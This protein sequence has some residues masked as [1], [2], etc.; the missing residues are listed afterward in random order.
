MQEPQEYARVPGRSTRRWKWQPTLTARHSWGL[1]DQRASFLEGIPS[2][3]ITLMLVGGRCLCFFNTVCRGSWGELEA[4]LGKKI[5]QHKGRKKKNTWDSNNADKFQ[6]HLPLM[7]LFKKK[8]QKKFIEYEQG[9]DSLRSWRVRNFKEP[10]T[11][12]EGRSLPT[13]FPSAQ[14]FDYFQRPAWGVPHGHGTHWR[15][16]RAPLCRQ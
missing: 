9:K 13:G 11:R 3:N 5:Y 4:F 6:H 8:L 7:L 1:N 10:W 15:P 14:T 12:K 2:F 16:C